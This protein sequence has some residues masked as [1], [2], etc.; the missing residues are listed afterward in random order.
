[1]VQ[2][3]RITTSVAKVLRAFLED[4]NKP[5]YGFDLM[6]DTGL[7]S[8]SLY[9]ILTRLRVTGWLVAQFE[10]IDE[11]AEG[12]PARRFYTLSA[13]GAAAARV[14]L[15]ELHQQIWASPGFLPVPGTGA[16]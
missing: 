11:K 15:A 3:V 12:R 13:D 8:G 16:T 6:R 7:A 2:E 9:P 5:R 10:E 4:V 1:M 14:S